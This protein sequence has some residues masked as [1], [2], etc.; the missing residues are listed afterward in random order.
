M[1][2]ELRILLVE[3]SEE[4]AF[5]LMNAKETHQDCSSR[6]RSMLG[7]SGLARRLVQVESVV[8]A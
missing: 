4:D 3:D 5:L 1:N 6:N 7:G 8:E 2:P